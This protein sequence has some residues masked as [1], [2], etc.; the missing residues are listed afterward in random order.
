MP[1]NFPHER[2]RVE[3]RVAPS[4]AFTGPERR[5]SQ[6]RADGV[7][8][9]RK[10]QRMHPGVLWAAIFMML[11]LADSVWLDGAYRRMVTGGIMHWLLG[12]RDWSD[13]LWDWRG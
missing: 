2:R 13:H 1:Y 8:L 5:L 11:V 4:P 7:K 10:R 3:R 6:R 12:V 9:V